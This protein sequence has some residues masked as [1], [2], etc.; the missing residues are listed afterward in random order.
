MLR[1]TASINSVSHSMITYTTLTYRSTMT[2]WSRVSTSTDRN[3]HTRAKVESV[4]TSSTNSNEEQERRTTTTAATTQLTQT[5]RARTDTARPKDRTP[6]SFESLVEDMV[7]LTYH[8][9]YFMTGMGIRAR[10]DRLI[11]EAYTISKITMDQ[12]Y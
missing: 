6:T 1:A 8:E 5:S 3:L 11:L 10:G 2:S 7:G 12:C 9:V 4:P